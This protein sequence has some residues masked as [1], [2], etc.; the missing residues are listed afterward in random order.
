MLFGPGLGIRLQ[1]MVEDVEK[2]QDMLLVVTR[3]AS[4]DVIDNHLANCFRPVLLA[5]KIFGKSGRSDLRYMLV[6]RDGE[7]LF[8][9]KA[10]KGHTV[11]KGDHG[12][13]SI[14]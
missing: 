1:K 5:H 3:L 4:A 10:A 6:L 11:L 8:F 13:L 14:V 7:H 9:C 2:D 12:Q